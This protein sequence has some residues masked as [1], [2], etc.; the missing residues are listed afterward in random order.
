MDAGSKLGIADGTSDGG[1]ENVMTLLALGSGVCG[2]LG[3]VVSGT[4]GTSGVTNTLSSTAVVNAALLWLV[5][6]NPI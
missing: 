4:G 5:T 2:T 6:A 3:G 1:F